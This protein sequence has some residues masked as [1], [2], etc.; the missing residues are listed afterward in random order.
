MT[1]TDFMNEVIEQLDLCDEDIN[2]GTNLQDIDDYDSFAILSLVALIH[3]NFSIQ[4]KANQLQNV[5]TIL[6]LISLIGEDKFE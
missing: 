2:F 5:K 1:K 4:L 3:K 6:E